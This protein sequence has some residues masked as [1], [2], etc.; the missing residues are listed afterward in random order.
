M[1]REKVRC[2]DLFYLIV[3]GSFFF[4]FLGWAAYHFNLEKLNNLSMPTSKD[5]ET[6]WN[7]TT[8]MYNYVRIYGPSILN[9]ECVNYCAES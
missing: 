5:G 6:C 3:T 8:Q 7:E 9:R 2:A 4:G 1:I